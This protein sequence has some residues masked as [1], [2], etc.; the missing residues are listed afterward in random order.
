M[1]I[2][3]YSGNTNANKCLIAAKFGN[4]T[5][6]YPDFKMGVDNKTEEFLKK[7][8]NGQV[9]TL[10]TE[11]GAIWESNAM[12]RYVARKGDRTLLGNGDYEASQV[13][14]WIEWTRSR[15]EQH[16]WTLFAPVLGY[17]AFDQSKHDAALKSIGEAFKVLDTHLN[18]KEFIVGGHSTLA[19]ICFVVSTS[20]V[21]AHILTKSWMTTYP[22]VASFFEKTIAKDQFRSV[23]GDKYA[24][25]PDKCSEPNALKH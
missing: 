4:Q 8:P 2:L 15:L 16:T 25:F 3:A 17:N 12:A 21:A 19:D 1:K 24:A 6:E 22:N 20:M 23:L 14:Q 10:D 7:N 13:D 18:G 9:P 11:E 5:I